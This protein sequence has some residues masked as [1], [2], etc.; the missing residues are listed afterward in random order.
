MTP[1]LRCRRVK[2]DLYLPG[3]QS[4]WI[5]GRKAAEDRA[6]WGKLVGVR[7]DEITVAYL[8]RTAHYRNHDTEVLGRVA[9]PG[10]KVRVSER[11]RM[12]GVDLGDG[13]GRLSA[14]P[15]KRTS[16]RRAATSR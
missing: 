12:L 13:T 3:H 4:H 5:Q 2:C 14:S 9:E 8:D 7:G 15:W 10:M 16:S 1:T 6:S 11:F